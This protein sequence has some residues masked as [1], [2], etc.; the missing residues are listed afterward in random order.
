M[1]QTTPI[2][3][4]EPQP[5]TSCRRCEQVR[6]LLLASITNPV[7]A[8]PDDVVVWFRKMIDL[9]IEF[10]PEMSFAKIIVVDTGEPSFDPETTAR[11]DAAMRKACRMFA[12]P[13]RLVSAIDPQV[14]SALL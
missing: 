2:T 5:E 3:D 4:A 8:S 6:E 1:D 10:Y 12:D 13:D 11:M 9:G 14:P 7:I